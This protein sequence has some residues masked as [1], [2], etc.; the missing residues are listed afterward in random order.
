[1]SPMSRPIP[2]SGYEEFH[3]ENV[4]VVQWEKPGYRRD[5]GDIGADVGRPTSP[6]S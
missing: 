2:G 3:Y 4:H 6:M 5:I 1:M